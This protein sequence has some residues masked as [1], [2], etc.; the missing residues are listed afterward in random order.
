[1]RLAVAIHWPRS[2][3]V[4]TI[5]A[6][7]R[8]PSRFVPR[9]LDPAQRPLVA[10]VDSKGE[11]MLVFRLARVSTGQSIIGANG[12]PE[13]NGNLLIAVPGSARRPGVRDR[14][15]LMSHRY[16]GGLAY[17]NEETG[18]PVI[19]R[20]GSM[21]E[22]VIT[23]TRP[24]LARRARPI[25]SD[26]TGKHLSQPER[27]LVQ[28]Y[29]AWIG[30]RTRFL[31]GNLRSAPVHCD[32]FLPSKYLLYE[33]KA[34]VSREVLRA[35]LGQLLDYQRYFPRRPRL[36]LLLPERPSQRMLDLF[37]QKRVVVIWRSPTGR[38]SDSLDGELTA[39]MREPRSA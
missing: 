11:V 16:V 22:R 37:A 30:E 14:R 20:A 33:A 7:G 13:R 36:A 31:S 27:R 8:C 25:I 38:F 39:L 24:S 6:S 10:L 19:L 15:H 1:M 23:D 12:Q 34:S 28:E 21:S 5:L 3:R 4:G 9:R 17:F 29:K 32:L 18:A 26:N 35:A 2:K